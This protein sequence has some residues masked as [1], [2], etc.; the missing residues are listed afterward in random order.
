MQLST[1]ST[2]LNE[3]KALTMKKL[4]LASVALLSL[5]SPVFGQITVATGMTPQQ[6]VENVLIGSGVTVSNFSFTGQSGQIGSFNG[7]SSNIGFG[8][9]IVL[10]SGLVNTIPGNAATN[11]DNELGGAGDASL[12]AV[13]Q[14]VT[15]NPNASS[16][17]STNDAAI[18][19]F[20]FVPTSNSVTFN[21]VF[22]SDEYTGW[23]NTVYND[24]FGF[25]LSGPGITGPYASPSGFPNGAVNLA[26]VPGTN[27]PITISTIHP[28]LNAQYYVSN[29]GGT[30]HT[31]NG[32]TV[33][34]P[35]E[36]AVQCGQTYHFKFAVSDCQDQFLNTAV[37]LEANSFTSPPVDLSITT[38]NG[39]NSV[40]EGCL[41]ASIYFIRNECQSSDSLWV[42][43]DISG[44][45]T[46]GVDYNNLTNPILL[47]PGQD[48]AV[49]NVIPIVDQLIEG[50]EYLTI[51]M[52]LLDQNGDTVVVGGTLAI[53]DNAPLVV[54]ATDVY[55]QCIPDVLPLVAS[56]TGGI[57]AISYSWS[58]GTMVN[59]SSTTVPANGTY[60]YI[61]TA[62][63]ACGGLDTDTL[64]IVMNQTINV[65]TIYMFPATACNPDGAVSAVVSGLTGQ[66]LYHWYGPG[67]PGSF[68]IDAS[69]LEDIPSGWYYF[70]VSDNVCSAKDSAFVTQSN[71]PVAE[72][73][74]SVTSGCS[75]VNVTFTNTSQN[76]T[77]YEWTFG[78]GQTA[79]VNDLSSQTQT[80]TASAIVQLVAFQGA[81]SDTATVAIGVSI[82][83]CTDPSAL[84]YDPSATQN[85]GSCVYPIPPYPTAEAPNVFTPGPGDNINPVF[86]LKTTN[87]ENVKLTIMNRWGNTVFEES[88]T[89]PSWDGKVDGTDVAEGVY[90]Y[91][92]VITGTG[93]A[94]TIEGHGFVQVE[95]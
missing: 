68:Q 16:I 90:F 52:T 39:S 36:F 41:D 22:A 4:L 34:I 93:G 46:E 2:G 10:S 61:V 27:V 21:F 79:N 94:N 14:S 37:F 9:G 23:I 63:D 20:D 75:P 74:P 65:D 62:T 60:D 54:T 76:T 87:A 59:P 31:F 1:A 24:A 69:V 66:P 89:N 78:N 33:P 73:T 42:T 58:N 11:P 82:C 80:Y 6:Y 81:C 64:T 38:A 51:H 86:Q 8:G 83:G 32:F 77:S 25:F 56:A 29:T 88:G 45:A 15:S 7:T 28:G 13:A 17:T 26:L 44:T 55:D 85:N 43:Y 92:Y 70:S 5:F 3:C 91:K 19:E 71:P 50:T 84:N 35:V 57:G 95:R 49:I 12:L 40:T 72:F 30:T 67:T 47:L 53:I 18:L 48:S